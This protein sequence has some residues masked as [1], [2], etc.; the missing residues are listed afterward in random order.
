GRSRS[1]GR[2]D[3][4]PGRP[5][6]VRAGVAV[7]SPSRPRVVA[8]TGT[9]VAFLVVVC[10]LGLAVS[11][12]VTNPSLPL[13]LATAG[14]IAVAVWMFLEPRLER[15]LAVLLVYLGALDGYLKLKT[16][17]SYMTLARDVLLYSIALGALARNTLLRRP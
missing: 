15:S 11:T 17:S 6:L 10:G 8:W 13:T 14:F 12:R 4:E 9:N 5:P 16:G 2:G 1:P 7:L 3:A